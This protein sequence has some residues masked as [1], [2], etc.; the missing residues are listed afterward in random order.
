MRKWAII[1]LAAIG[2]LIG[3]GLGAQTFLPWSIGGFGIATN[4]SQ[5]PAP[6]PN[7][8]ALCA[9]VGQG[10]YTTVGSSPY[11]SINGLPGPQGNPGPS[12]PAGATGATGPQGIQGPA[13]QNG[14]VGQQGPAGQGF[15]INTQIGFKCGKGTGTIQ[16]GAVMACTVT[17]ITQ[18][19]GAK[20][21]K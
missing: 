12:G 19:A 8:V 11:K 3:V 2:A 14:A 16:S 4:V 10:F 1:V 9:V 5:C 6:A 18:P 17:S 21:G 7:F 15:V 13:G 20:K